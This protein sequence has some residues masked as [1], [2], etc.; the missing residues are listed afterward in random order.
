M[1]EETEAIKETAKATQEVA[2]TTS[3][4]IDAGREMD[5][6]GLTNPNKTIPLKNAVPLLEY[7]TLEEDDNLQDMWARLLVNG[8]SES[9]G[10]NIERSFIE[11]LAQISPL[12]AQILQA[13]YALPFDKTRNTGVATENLPEFATVVEDKPENKPKE[14]SQEVKLALAN[15]VRIGCLKFPATWDGGEIFTQIN[16][17]LIGNEFVAACTFK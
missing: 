9:T 2:K 5:E 13:I 6:Q 7:A 15:L 1:S 16:T 12:E 8:T 10:I 4:A 11:I 14:P 17:T 3:N